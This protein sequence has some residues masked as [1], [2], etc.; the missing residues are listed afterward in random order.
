MRREVRLAGF[1]GQGIILASY[2]IGKAAS[3]HDDQHAVMT[4][5]Y[6]PEARGGACAAAVVLS[7]EAIDYPLVTRPDCLVV[8]SQEAYGT[9]RDHLADDGLLVADADVA[10]A[11]LSAADA[12]G[13]HQLHQV[14]ALRLADQLGRRIVANIVMLGFWTA[15]AKYV[16][17]GAMEEAIR[18]TV[19]PRTV[20][21]NLRAFASGYEFTHSLEAIE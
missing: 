12:S 13:E 2:I 19:P 4:Q 11:P 16:S 1:G 18:S 5:S 7:D 8:L 9:Y 17:R 14:P 6:G 21:L 20:D 10:V 3:L 15:V